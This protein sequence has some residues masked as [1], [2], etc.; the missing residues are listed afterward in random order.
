MTKAE[1]YEKWKSGSR[2]SMI[3]YNR[4]EMLNDLD[5]VV[6]TAVIGWKQFVD[7]ECQKTVDL[8][9]FIRLEAEAIQNRQ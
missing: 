6:Y 5:R 7:A 4:E 8:D 3:F 2:E 1:F 9:E